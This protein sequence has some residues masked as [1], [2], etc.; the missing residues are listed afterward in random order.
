MQG[1]RAYY[2]QIRSVVINIQLRR[3]IFEIEDKE[4][5]YNCGAQAL[6]IL[7]VGCVYR[8]AQTQYGDYS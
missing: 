7:I 2:S 3:L 6:A 8:C 1:S 5:D 4:T